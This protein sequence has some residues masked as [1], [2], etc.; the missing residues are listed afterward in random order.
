MH[1]QPHDDHDGKKVWLSERECEQYLAGVEDTSK[2][3][4]C[5]LALWS[6]L[7]VGEI[8]SV[9]PDHV[10]AAPQGTML[11][12]PEANAKGRNI[13]R[14]RSHSTSPQ[15]TG[16]STMSAGSQTRRNSWTRLSGRSGGGWQARRA[17]RRGDRRRR[18]VRLS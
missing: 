12:V 11:R 1:R 8:V 2:R 14:R 10:D 15:R 16:M 13:G 7:R 6:G 9:A 18:V 17:L 3:I 5:G 4:A